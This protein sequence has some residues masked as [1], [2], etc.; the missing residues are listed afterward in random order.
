MLRRQRPFRLLA[1][2]AVFACA[3]IFSSSASAGIYSVDVYMSGPEAAVCA[4]RVQ[5]R[6]GHE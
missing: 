1:A 6:P 3:A 2:L 4:N 5:E